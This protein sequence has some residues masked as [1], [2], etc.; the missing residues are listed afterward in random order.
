MINHIILTHPN[1][2]CAIISNCSNNYGPN[3]FPEKLIPLCI[4]NIINRKPIPI[5]GQGTIVRDW[6]YVEDHA[7]AIDVVYHKGTPGET[8]NIG[9]DNEWKNINMVQLVCDIMDRK[10][11]RNEGESR[12]L[13]S[14]VK[15]RA[16]H[17]QRYAI[18]AS[19]I[20]RE[21][22]WHPSLQFEKGLEKTIDWYINNSEW[23]ESVTSGDY[24][25]YYDKQYSK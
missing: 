1:R 18:D 2:T 25:Q 20:K 11:G 7:R 8:Y 4:Y 14:F 15:D 16:G 17:D 13:I 19:K 24:R 10:L 6:L 22:G 21:L 23:L 12:E 9:G 5:Y 3:Q